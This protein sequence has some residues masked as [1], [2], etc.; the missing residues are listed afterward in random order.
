VLWEDGFDYETTTNYEE[1]IFSTIMNLENGYPALVLIN[2]LTHWVAVSG[3]SEDKI[4]IV[5]SM[6]PDANSEWLGI[7]EFQKEFNSAIMLTNYGPSREPGLVAYIRN[8]NSGAKL[9]VL[10]AGKAWIF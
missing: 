1:F 7:D 5:D 4:C 3:I 6:R 10:A 2:K 8:Y 9:G